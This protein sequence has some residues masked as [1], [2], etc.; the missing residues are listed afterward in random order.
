METYTYAPKEIQIT[1]RAKLHSNLAAWHDNKALYK[2]FIND[3]H[4]E[5]VKDSEIGYYLPKSYL[6]IT[7]EVKRY[8]SIR[9]KE[10]LRMHRKEYASKQTEIDKR[11]SELENEHEMLKTNRV[12]EKNDLDA[13][14][15]KLKSAKIDDDRIAIESR[16][17][18]AESKLRNT[19]VAIKN[20]ENEV[21]ALAKTKKK[22]LVA[23]DNQVKTVEKVVE[24]AIGDYIKKAT[25]RI[26]LV[27]G[28]TN[29]THQIA[30]YDNEILKKVKGEY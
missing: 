13:L 6:I 30:K 15:A 21:S 19:D 25:K 2:Q 14:K 18:Q 26:E 22:N 10:L 28:F 27:Y 4:L 7:D 9:E 12:K 1:W 23:W 11:T 29:Y 8:Y 17:S 20:C 16:I 24:I 3:Q 5:K